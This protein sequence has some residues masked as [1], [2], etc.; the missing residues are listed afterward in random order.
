MNLAKSFSIYTIASF[1]NK[2][3]MALL[4][5]FLSHY[6]LPAENGVLSMYTI[7]VALVLPF[8]ILGMPSSIMLEHSKLNEK[9]FKLYFN[10]SLALSAI[11]F[12]LL[13]LIFFITGKYIAA[14]LN[15]PIRFLLMGLLYAWFNF[16]QE[17]IT[18]YI[19]TT[20]QPIFFLWLS[21]IRDVI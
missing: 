2:G 18:S 7:F 6:I 19:R 9:E 13:L 14:S 11:S 10:S 12:L 17:N 20:N 15:V 16:F 1:F 8:I 3:L 5:F 21:I 4:A